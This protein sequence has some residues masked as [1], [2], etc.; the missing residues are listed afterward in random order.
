MFRD[1]EIRDAHI[2]KAPFNISVKGFKYFILSLLMEVTE[3]Y[4]EER[5]FDTSV[6]SVLGLTEGFSLSKKIFYHVT[7][8]SFYCVVIV[9]RVILIFTRK[10]E[11]WGKSLQVGNLLLKN[12]TQFLFIPVPQD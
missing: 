10:F 1:E 5:S 7:N 2:Y 11:W 8:H 6:P 9:L 12:L 3:Y 4:D